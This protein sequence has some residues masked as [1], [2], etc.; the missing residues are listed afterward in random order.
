V[1]ITGLMIMV[2]LGTELSKLSVGRDIVIG[3]GF[4]VGVGDGV[5]VVVKG[6]PQYLPPVSKV[7][8]PSYPPQTIIS[9]PVQ[10]AVCTSRPI[11]ALLV[12]IAV[13]LSVPGL[14]LPPVLKVLP[15]FPTPPHTIISVPVQTAV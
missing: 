3:A 7:L 9:V 10:V 13:Q 4:G 2:E 6:S 8:I 5:G 1:V 11:G 14:Y 15:L 12:L